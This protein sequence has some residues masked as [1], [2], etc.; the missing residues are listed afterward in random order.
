V[1]PL[2]ATPWFEHLVVKLADVHLV[3]GESERAVVVLSDAVATRPTR[4]P[5]ELDHL[6]ALHVDLGRRQDAVALL[7]RLVADHRDE[8]GL[9][10][11]LRAVAN[12][13]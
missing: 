7:R 9:S 6:I 11:R 13:A 4:C 5:A 8:P 3:A 2:R 12:G 10:E 1:S